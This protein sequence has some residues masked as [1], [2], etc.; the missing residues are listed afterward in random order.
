[1]A[2]K[3]SGTTLRRRTREVTMKPN[4]CAMQTLLVHGPK[5]PD[6]DLCPP[7]HMTSAFRFESADHGA[8]I[9]AGNVAGHAYSR[10][11]NP[12]GALLEEHLALI[13]GGEAA[14]ATAS[15]MA[16][17]AAVALSLL[18]PGDNLVAGQALYGGTYALFNRH[19]AELGIEARF[20]SPT[21]HADQVA[22][23]IDGRTRLV[24]LETPAN[25][26]LAVGDIAAWA[27]AAHQH[28]AL[29]AVDNTFATPVLQNPLA[30]GADL[31]VHSA[32]KYLG[33]HADAIGGAVIGSHSLLTHIRERYLNHFGP[34]I[35]PFNAWL[36]ARGIKTL[37]LRMERH[38]ANAL[39]L[40][41]QLV[42]HPAVERVH[43]PG[44]P[45]HPAHELAARQMRGFGGMLAFD[46]RDGQAAGK[47]LMN[48]VRLCTL[49]VSLGDCNTL[50]QH[51]ASMT[52]ATYAPEA[53]RAAGIGDGLVRISVGIEDVTDIV[54]DIE[55]ALEYTTK[56][57]A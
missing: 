31:V 44:L 29:L 34:C 38:S 23:R 26:T 11:S 46:L 57:R 17:I 43:Y 1:M 39:A 2:E 37:A 3:A 35:S 55:M 51:P 10:I 14:A 50:I 33:G 47:A 36:I 32:T 15:G 19:L 49:A 30:L 16:A 40:A 21:S 48:H 54:A 42:R 41:R 56:S 28:G 5:A 22:A 9:F 8:G 27:S 18:G 52:H 45:D 6:P 24:Y 25:P 53:R 4:R 20:I 12:G 13:E 7:L